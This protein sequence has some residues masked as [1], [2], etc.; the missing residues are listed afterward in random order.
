MP[1]IIDVK[2]TPAWG[3][4]RFPARLLDDG[5]NIE[6][7]MG[8]RRGDA[9]E[10]TTLRDVAGRMAIGAVL[11]ATTGVG[12]M[13]MGAR[14]LE[15]GVHN[16]VVVATDRRVLMLN[17]GMVSKDV[18]QVP[19]Q[20]LEVDY[21]EGLT[22][23]GLEILRQHGPRLRLLPRPQR[24]EGYKEPGQAAVRMRAPASSRRGEPGRRLAGTE[25]GR[26]PEHRA[27]GSIPCEEATTRP[28]SRPPAAARFRM[29]WHLRQKRERVVIR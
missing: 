11:N 20:G 9:T 1:S 19:Y 7:W 17:S 2:K 16:G 24:Q 25:T 6:Y 13:G 5:E 10:F 14:G 15:L 21:N 27:A 8:G 23:L 12:G 3:E 28:S 4:S 26:W 29:Q 22:Y 18:V